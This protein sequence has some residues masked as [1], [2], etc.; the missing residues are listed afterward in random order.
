MGDR[1]N[2]PERDATSR[3]KVFEIKA[4][5]F[6]SSVSYFGRS[7]GGNFGLLGVRGVNFPPLM[8]HQ[9]SFSLKTSANEN[10][11][12]IFYTCVAFPNQ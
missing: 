5:M 12:Y 8:L 7:G 9:I 3:V 2:F 4:N 1:R 11:P 6:K 10:L